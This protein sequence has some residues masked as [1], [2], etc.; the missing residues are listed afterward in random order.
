MIRRFARLALAGTLLLLQATPLRVAAAV[1]N[2]D[3]F[4]PPPISVRTLA[5]GL[6]VVV[7]ESHAVPVVQVAMW[8]RFGSSEEKP[9]KTGL[10][11]ALEHMMFRGTPSLSDAGLDDVI[12]RIGAQVNADTTTDDTHFFA[13]V[14]RD[15]VGLWMRIEADRMTHLT[16]SEDLWKLEK[17]AVLQ[18]YD[19]DYSQPI[20]KLVMSVN[21]AAYGNDPLGRGA[22]GERNDIV[23]STAADIRA[24]YARW[25]APNNAVVVLT[26]DIKPDE[27]FVLAQSAFARIGEKRLPPR[28]L[29][30][31][32]VHS[33]E[34]IEQTGDVPFETVDF[35]YAIPG[36]TDRAVIAPLLI[37]LAA[38]N[39]RSPIR[40]ALVNSQIAI[41]Y[42]ATPVLTMR[43]SMFHL[44]VTLAPGRTMQ[45]ARA[46]WEGAFRQT[47]IDGY[48]TDLIDAAKRAAIVQ[49]VYDRDSLTG[50]GELVGNSFGVEGGTYPN[51][52]NADIA[53]VSQATVQAAAKQMF[54]KPT[55]VARVRPRSSKP[56]D[57]QPANAKA[58]TISDTF[59]GRLPSGNI[60]E[61]SWV[62][63][64]LA[65]S[66]SLSSHVAPVAFTL[67]NGLRL[68]VQ[69]A[70]ENPTVTISGRIDNSPRSD[71]PGKEGLGAVLT[72][73]MG[74]GSAKYPFETERTIADQLAADVSYGGT[75]GAHGLSRDFPQLL[76]LIADD[77]KA[78]ALPQEF[79]GLIR[80]AIKSNVARQ[81]FDPD[82]RAARAF[83]EALLPPGDPALRQPTAASMDSLTLADVKSM[84]SRI[85]R[86]ETTILV[87]V[88]D[89]SA[90]DVRDRVT[91]A[92]GSWHADGAKIDL[93]MPLIPEPKGGA[94]D[95]PTQSTDVAVRMGQPAIARGSADFDAF[96]LLD[97]IFGGDSFDSRL[98]KEIRMRRGLVYNIYSGL[99]SDRDR[100]I[101]EIAFRASPRNVGRAVTLVKGEMR[102]MQDQPV[103]QTEL[104]RARSRIVGTTVIAEQDRS[105]LVG[106]LLNIAENGLPLD[107]YATLAQRYDT[108]GAD[109]I[110]RI[111]RTYLHP[112]RMVEVYQGPVAQ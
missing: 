27:A 5:N 110:Q 54:A 58:S 36:Q 4:P 71:P 28:L 79:F 68:L 10:A 60:V 26:G 73:M 42:S 59:S 9:G 55:V 98:F 106:D 80:D 21:R 105:T 2:P 109:A 63:D 14:P 41:Q 31:P 38:E 19:A 52:D 86:P 100:G 35:A 75:F 87:V 83:Q 108:I 44:I 89:V 57:V 43:G 50:L 72:S 7:A 3:E 16:L 15:R 95:V 97:Q 66:P 30:K 74:Y 65:K 51:R 99:E 24:Y 111:A 37:S 39:A 22:L 84:A 62:R 61:A 64:A 76:D 91:A 81:A 85:L 25:Y 20:G 70:H 29:T 6:K 78:P 77:I 49:D 12:A 40:S 56:G 46:A 8:Y 67:P 53:T 82:Y 33:G 102:R 93:S 69:E 101:F 103:A 92:L 112:N 34:T 13:L 107:Y 23:R 32:V 90:D 45:E 104:L 96:S 18:E 1:P 48:P 17:G 11:H 47:F 94:I 88:G